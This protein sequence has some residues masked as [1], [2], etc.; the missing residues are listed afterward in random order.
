MS[1]PQRSTQ[2]TQ[3]KPITLLRVLMTAFAVAFVTYVGSGPSTLLRAAL[4]LSKGGFSRTVLAQEATTSPGL[5]RKG[6]VPVSNEILKIKLPRPAEADLSNG[7]HL[8]VLEDHRLPEISFQLIIPGA[9]GFFDPA[10][11]PGLASFTASLMRE[12]TPT[13]TSNQISAQLDLMAATLNMNAGNTSTEAALNGSSFSD[14]A[15]TLFDLAADLL[16]HPA[17][18]EDEVVRFKQR[19]RTNLAQQRANPNFLAAE[20]FSRAVY[21]SH[22]ASRVAPTV[23]SLERTTR[24]QLVEFHRTHYVPDRAVLAIAGDISLAQARVLAESRLAAWTKSASPVTG[25]IAEPAPV[26]GA[27][28]YLVARPSSVQTNLIV[29]TQAIERTNPDYDM[30]Q[31]M[32]KVIGGGPTGRLF[33]HLREDKGYTYGAGSVLDARQHRGD[34]AASTN[35]RTEVT[36][37]ALRDLLD[38]IRQLRDEP[39]PERELADAKRSMIASFALSLESPAQL[40][41]LS[42]TSWRYKLP[43]DYWDRYPERVTAVTSAQV[44]AIARKYLATDRLQIVAVGD[45][46]PIAGPLKKLGVVESYDANGTRLEN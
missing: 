4:S 2:S 12:G 38:E 35:V 26:V 37:P 6:K 13:R 10:E 39:V 45:P 11:Q 18:A 27:K 3:R 16:L 9:G 40:L 7:L 5:V 42:V 19:T 15:S 34:W 36:E 41:G 8:I 44:Q 24:Q 43:A 20:M 25:S 33:L 32:N 14:Q 22:P 29:G 30:L 28:V 17:F 31:V 1:W 21:G 23:A 46:G